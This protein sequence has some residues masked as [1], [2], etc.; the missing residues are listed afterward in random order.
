MRAISSLAS[1]LV[2]AIAEGRR[3]WVTPVWESFRVRYRP[4]GLRLNPEVS[5]STDYSNIQCD[6]ERSQR[7]PL[8]GGDP[9]SIGAQSEC[10]VPLLV[11][12]GGMERLL[13]AQTSAADL[14]PHL[15]HP[16]QQP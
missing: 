14:P 11:I 10:V 15:L 7:G 9:A 2:K 6:R 5:E 8:G 3:L 4:S 16:I 1:P 13:L 12:P